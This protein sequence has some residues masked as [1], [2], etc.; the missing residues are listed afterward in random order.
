M[1]ISMNDVRRIFA[2]TS[3]CV[4]DQLVA[5]MR[6]VVRL[7]ET[8]PYRDEVVASMDGFLDLV[9]FRLLHDDNE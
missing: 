9:E 8:S 1:T 2:D 3:A 5:R 4:G 7:A 6:E